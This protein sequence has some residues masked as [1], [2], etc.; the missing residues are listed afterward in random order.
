MDPS[1][2]NVGA[3]TLGLW[4]QVARSEAAQWAGRA[5]KPV[6]RLD[7]ELVRLIGVAVDALVAVEKYVDA[8][9]EARKGLP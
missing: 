4:M 1:D 7:P 3:A 9:R 2:K 8:R 5:M 6:A